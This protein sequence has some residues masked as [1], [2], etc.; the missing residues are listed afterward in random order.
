[1]CTAT[2]ES[3]GQFAVKINKVDKVYNGCIL[4]IYC[5]VKGKYESLDTTYKCPSGKKGATALT[6]SIAASILAASMAI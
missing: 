3:C 1:M 2:N 5:G 6:M 4:S